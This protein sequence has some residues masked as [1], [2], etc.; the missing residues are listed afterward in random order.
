[1]NTRV[2]I[3]VKPQTIQWLMDELNSGKYFLPSFQRQYVWD[4]DDIKDLVD[5][6]IKNYPIGTVI[7]WKPSKASTSEIDPF[8]KPLVDI[9]EGNPKEVIYVIDGQQRL[10][11]LL[12]LLNN[13]EIERSGERISTNPISYNP[14]NN[15]FYKSTKRGID[16]S[17]LIKAFYHYDAA[18]MSELQQATPTESYEEMKNLIK[19]ML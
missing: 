10:T 15:K 9:G 5:S 11:S 12:L 3:D 13:W 1:M 6:I 8:S 4:E 18:A 17:K 7:L 19:E 14:A 16:L 2:K